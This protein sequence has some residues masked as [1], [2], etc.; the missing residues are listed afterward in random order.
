MNVGEFP[1]FAPKH[2]QLSEIFFNLKSNKEFFAWTSSHVTQDSQS[3]YCCHI[4]NGLCSPAQSS[5]AQE[6]VKPVPGKSR[7]QCY[8]DLRKRKLKQKSLNLWCSFI[9]PRCDTSRQISL[10]P[11]HNPILPIFPAVSFFQLTNFTVFK[12]YSRWFSCFFI[13]LIIYSLEMW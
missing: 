12:L 11:S 4:L 1:S 3:L 6:F 7:L 5:G 10:L 8:K 13:F 9:F 2:Y